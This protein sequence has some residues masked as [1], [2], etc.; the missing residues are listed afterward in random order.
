MAKIKEKIKNIIKAAKSL[1]DYTTN[2]DS[3]NACNIDAKIARHNY[4]LHQEDLKQ[5]QQNCIKK[6]CDKINKVSSNGAQYFDTNCFIVDPDDKNKIRWI[7]GDDGCAG[8]FPS[9]AT[10]DYFK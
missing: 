5:R 3:Y 6:W 7:V 10:L 1:D 4:Q 8:A 2:C 9:N